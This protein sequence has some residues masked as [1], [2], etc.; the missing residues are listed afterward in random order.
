MPPLTE[1]WQLYLPR[2]SLEHWYR[3]AKQ[4]LH[5]TVPKLSTPEQCQQWSDLMPLLTW[6]LC[7]AKD[8][9]T[10][11]RLQAAK[12]SAS[13]DAW[14]GCTVNASTFNQDWDSGCCSQTARKFRRMANRKVSHSKMSLSCG[15]KG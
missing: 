14:K 9:V 15:Q 2:F 10:E 12:V 1:I 3:L 4:T 11:I 6:Q 13:I 5:W 8:V 7:L